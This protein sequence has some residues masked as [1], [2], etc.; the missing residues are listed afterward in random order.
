MQLVL[1]SLRCSN[2]FYGNPTQEGDT[3]KPCNCNLDLNTENDGDA[4]ICD[5]L[6]GECLLCPKNTVGWNCDECLSGHF[7]DPLNG[8]CIR[9]K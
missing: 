7:G 9:M 6:T 5:H 2:G 4:S 3:C 8:T 1:A